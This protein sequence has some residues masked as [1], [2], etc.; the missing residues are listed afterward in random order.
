M[1]EFI[2]VDGKD[3]G[4]IKIY[5]LSTCGWCKKA[6][7]FFNERKIAYAYVDVDLL[8]SDDLSAVKGEQ[9]KFNPNTSYPT[10]VV[11][12]EKVIIGFNEPRLMNLVGEV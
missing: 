7:R 5:A 2:K 8:S 4:D 3:I 11:N 1:V 9:A 10:I 12:G 6:K